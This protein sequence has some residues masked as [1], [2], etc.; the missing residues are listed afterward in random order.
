VKFWVFRV[1]DEGFIELSPPISPSVSPCEI[2]LCN[3]YTELKLFGV[4]IENNKLALSN[5]SADLTFNISF[6]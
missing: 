2:Y 6:A 5:F 1:F 4:S 3:D